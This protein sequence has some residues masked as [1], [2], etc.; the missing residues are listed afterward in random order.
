M[1]ASPL[2]VHRLTWCSPEASCRR[3]PVCHRRQQIAATTLLLHPAR[4]GCFHCHH[5]PA[6]AQPHL[7]PPS[8]GHSKAN[9]FCPQ[10][11]SAPC[12]PHLLWQC[13]TIYSSNCSS[14]VPSATPACHAASCLGVGRHEAV[15]VLP[16][17]PLGCSGEHPQCCQRDALGGQGAPFPTPPAAQQLLRSYCQ[18]LSG[19]QHTVIRCAILGAIL[20]ASVLWL[21]RSSAFSWSCPVLVAALCCAVLHDRF[22]LLGSALL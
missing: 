6:C 8:A 22:L 12:L 14:D 15:L 18:H 9:Q 11:H 13:A 21:L 4:P 2:C 20:G 1:P 16:P 5:E 17:A 19:K 10:R 3:T 7:L